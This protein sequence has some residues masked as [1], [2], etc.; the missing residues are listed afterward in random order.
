MAV[1]VHNDTAIEMPDNSRTKYRKATTLPLSLQNGDLISTEN[2]L[3]E[4]YAEITCNQIAKQYFGRLMKRRFFVK[5][6]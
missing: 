4:A 6:D 5:G 1:I 2:K 3:Y